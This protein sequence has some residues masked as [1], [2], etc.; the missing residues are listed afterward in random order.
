MRGDPA[1]KPPPNNFHLLLENMPDAFAY[2]QIVTDPDGNPIDYI[3]L[4]ANPAFEKMT[5]LARDRIIGKKVT[6]VLPDITKAS[7]DWIGTYG[8]VALTGAK[9]KFEQYDELTKNWYD[10]TAYSDEPG[11]FAVVFHNT[12]ESKKTATAL[13]ESEARFHRITENAQDLIY[14]L[15]LAPKRQFEYVNPAALAITGYSPEDHYADPDLG[16]KLVHP[17]DHPL[18]EAVAQAKIPLH[19]PLTL[20]WV[21]RDGEVIWT[22]QR[23]VPIYGEDGHLVALEGIARD[24]TASKK[25]QE[26]ELQHLARLKSLV[27][28]SQYQADTI[29]DLLDYA[30]SEAIQLTESKLGYVYHYDEETR[31]FILNSWSRGVLQ[32]CSIRNPATIY[33]LDKTGIWG[34]AIRQRKPIINNNFTLHHPLKKGYPEGHAKLFKFMTIPIFKD[35]Q[36]IAVVGVANKDQ[37]YE[38]KDVLQLTLL[39]DSVWKMVERKKSEKTLAESEGRYAMV[40]NNLPKG[41]VH[42]MDRDFRYVFSAGDGLRNVGHTAKD[43]FGKTMSD[44]ITPAMAKRVAQ[45]YRRAFAG[46]NVTYT[47]TYKG[48]E[49]LSNAIP[50]RHE[51]GKIDQLLVL[52]VDITEQKI[53]EEKLR[54]L[55]KELEQRVKDRTAQLEASNRELESFAYSVSHDLRSPLRAVAGY[56]QIILEDYTDILD[57]EAIRL[58][59]VVYSNTKQ[60]DRLITDLLELSRTARTRMNL[61]TVDMV[62]LVETIY[63]E[64]SPQDSERFTFTINPLPPA[65]GDRRLLHLAWQNLLD[66]A[67]KYTSPKE[68]PIIQVGGYTVNNTNIYFIKDNGVGFNPIYTHKIFETF[69]RLHKTEEFPGTGIGLAIVE[70]IINRHGGKVWAEGALNKGATLYFSLPVKTG[71]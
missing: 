56:S 6:E 5:G 37:D 32:E 26:M 21:R 65:L 40:V 27:D 63:A 61:A 2:H 4:N 18:L 29:Q 7:F 71:K 20:R 33:E 11:Y 36:I 3:F 64:L 23:N 12:T 16:F 66:N 30:L 46:E 28:I 57:Q 67:I 59:N 1:I 35:S 47:I 49:F 50:L 52:Q 25:S 44:M 13:L 41:V 14:R 31:Q 15:R 24:I 8:G 19:E 58:L 17:D 10:I 69:Q 22:E 48:R 9:I 54:R 53:A 34:E 55:N 39:M 70:R 38:E 45:N 60:M 68:N 43:F 42:I 51:D 62:P